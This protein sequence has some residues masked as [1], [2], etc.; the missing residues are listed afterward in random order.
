MDE[1]R[2]F[3]RYVTPDLVFGVQLLVLLSVLK[4]TWT[5]EQIKTLKNDQGTGVAIGI[6]LASGGLGYLFGVI[7]H[8]L[9]RLN[10]G[11]HWSTVDHSTLINRLRNANRIRILTS[12]VDDSH[13]WRTCLTLPVDRT[14][15]WIILTGMWWERVQKKG[16]IKSADSHTASLMDM[17]HSA[18]TA[19]IAAAAA[20][21]V[22]IIASVLIGNRTADWPACYQWLIAL[23]LG[24]ILVAMHHRNYL[25]LGDRAQALIDEIFADHIEEEVSSTGTVETIV[26]E[27]YIPAQQ[28]R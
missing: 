24:L 4:T 21:A 6:F 9:H 13:E 2:R 12:S 3:L 16:V 18:G 22:A 8:T 19:R 14:A 1:A 10:W 28:V 27:R 17:V 25:R 20:L 15:A 26:N 7:H 5:W 23:S 11:P